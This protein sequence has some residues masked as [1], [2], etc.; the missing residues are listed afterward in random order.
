MDISI[1]IKDTYRTGVVV[2][3][4]GMAGVSAALAAARSGANVILV[5]KQCLLGGLATLG[6]VTIF[7][8]LC[9][10]CGR[11]VTFGIAEEL[12]RLSIS[13]GCE[14][15][16]PACWLEN[17]GEERREKQRFEAQYNP[18]LFALELEKTLLH[19]GVR[20]LY[21]TKLLHFSTE[22]ERINYAVVSRTDGVYAIEADQY[23]DTTGELVGAASIG[24]K[25]SSNHSNMPAA[26]Y[27]S[28]SAKEGLKLRMLG[29]LETANPNTKT[30]KLSAETFSGLCAEENDRILNLSHRKMLE[31]I[32][33]M[34]SEQPEYVPATLP[35][36]LQVR[37][38]RRLSSNCIL[39]IKDDFQSFTDSI[40][41]ISNWKKRGPIYEVP[42]RCLFSQRWS[43]LLTAGRSIDVTDEMWDLSRVIPACCLTGQA[44]GTA[45]A[46]A[47][48][49]DIR[50]LVVSEL[51][52]KLLHDGVRIHLH[53]L[54]L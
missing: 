4:G 12:L 51:Q 1:K 27:Y 10:G 36:V 54:G 52:T 2:L 19:N 21:D 3:G 47:G 6:L 43:N 50:T 23:I 26:W 25:T 20:I 17:E 49:E 15:R 8:P 13:H 24:A 29:V 53:Q 40:G 5:E 28:L 22:E 31:H 30:E 9:D 44:A 35:A 33:K 45:A 48:K 32:L 34:Q 38:S 11:Q 16:Y 39:D 37:M 18:H 14:D 7:L 46:L 42:F 41:M